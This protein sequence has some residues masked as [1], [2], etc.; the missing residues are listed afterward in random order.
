MEEFEIICQLGSRKENAFR[1]SVLILGFIELSSKGSLTLLS[2]FS[3][4]LHFKNI[5]FDGMF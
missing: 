1:I 2:L 5:S 4:N 3:L